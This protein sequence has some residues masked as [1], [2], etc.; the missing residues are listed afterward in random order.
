M[1]PD[2]TWPE[3]CAAAF[4]A[5]IQLTAIGFKHPGGGVNGPYNYCSYGAAVAEVMVDVL[6]GEVQVERLDILFDCGTSL[7]P[8]VDIGQVR[9]VVCVC[10]FLERDGEDN[11]LCRRRALFGSLRVCPCPCCAVD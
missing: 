7:N 10:C 6:T 9:P 1:Y 3:V 8:I 11:C 2:Y 4:A 5:S